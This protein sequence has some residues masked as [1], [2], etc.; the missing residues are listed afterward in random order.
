[1]GNKEECVYVCMQ[2]ESSPGYAT[3]LLGNLGTVTLPLYAVV[4]LSVKWGERQ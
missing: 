3:D 1:M 2:L 4:C